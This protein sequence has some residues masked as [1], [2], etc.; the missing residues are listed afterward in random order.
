MRK[1]LVW[2]VVAWAGLVLVYLIW[3]GLTGIAAGFG[4]LV[5]LAA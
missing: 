1:F 2:P 3:R 4:Y 5:G